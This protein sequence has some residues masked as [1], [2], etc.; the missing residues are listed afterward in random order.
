MLNSYH[1]SVA[2]VRNLISSMQR[3]WVVIQPDVMV[4]PFSV[5]QSC[6]ALKPVE[7]NY[8]EEGRNV[9]QTADIPSK[10]NHGFP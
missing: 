7:G 4:T 1:G 2:A 10:G 8:V 5:S 9:W 6:V 3:L